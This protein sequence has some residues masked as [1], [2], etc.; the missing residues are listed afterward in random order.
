M[1]SSSAISPLD[2][3]PYKGLARKCAH[4]LLV[5]GEARDGTRFLR[6]TMRHHTYD[7]TL[8][9]KDEAGKLAV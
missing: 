2:Y 4:N 9:Y 5:T 7:Y 3:P 8:V 1:P 6:V